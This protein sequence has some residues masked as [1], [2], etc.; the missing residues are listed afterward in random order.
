LVAVNGPH[1]DSDGSNHVANLLVDLIEDIR[2]ERGDVDEF[3][4][5]GIV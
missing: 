1:R 5:V 3:P 2:A 4:I